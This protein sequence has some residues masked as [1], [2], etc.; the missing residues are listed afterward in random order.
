VTKNAEL[1]LTTLVVRAVERER[2]DVS[3]TEIVAAERRIVTS[4][5]GGSGAAYRAA[6]ARAGATVAVGRG[7][8]GDELRRLE[9]VPRLTVSNPP[10]AD[11]AR[12]RATHALASARAVSVTPAPSWLPEGE[13]IALG[14]RAPERVFRLPKGRVRTLRTAE[15]VF[16]VRALDATEPLG[17]LP[18]SEARRAI[19]RELLAERKAEAYAAWTIRKQKTAESRLVCSRDRLPEL[20]VVRLS[21]FVPFLSLHEPEAARWL[22]EQ[23][24]SAKR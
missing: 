1:A 17:V 6:L 21:S 2:A 5:F 19:V 20:A 3:P 18:Y 23:R 11:V 24:G 9:I 13:G 14:T 22:A 7:T 16:S 12:F 10:R 8:I 15:G 4:R